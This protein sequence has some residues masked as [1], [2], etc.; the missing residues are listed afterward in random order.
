MWN[1][2]TPLL[3]LFRSAFLGGPLPDALSIVFLLTMTAVT[4]GGGLL[5]FRRAQPGLVDLI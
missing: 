4:F 2:M 5:F 3:G 1:P